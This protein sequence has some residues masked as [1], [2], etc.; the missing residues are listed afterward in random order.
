V[1]HS[2]TLLISDSSPDTAIDLPATAPFT[3]GTNE[4]LTVEELDAM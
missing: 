1:S 3:D 4:D 2:D